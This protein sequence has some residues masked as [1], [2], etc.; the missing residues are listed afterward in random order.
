M[1]V[2]YTDPDN[3][4][5]KGYIWV[6]DPAAVGKGVEST[7]RY[8]QKTHSRRSNNSHLVDPKRQKS[9]RKGGRAARKSTKLRR[10]AKFD[11]HVALYEH[12]LRG[13]TPQY[14]HS[15]PGSYRCSQSPTMNQY[16]MGGLPYYLG[17]ASSESP[18][19]ESS[20]YSY[21]GDSVYPEIPADQN[22][23]NTSFETDSGF[24]GDGSG[25]LF[26][27]QDTKA[28]G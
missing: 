2:A 14:S 9:G 1:K 8:R 13:Q 3:K 24:L 26:G 11:D 22:L 5:K 7:T 20:P 21:S 15:S 10:F 12:C 25:E 6:L 17:R 23:L 16:N 28:F 18:H 19:P 4:H 27:A